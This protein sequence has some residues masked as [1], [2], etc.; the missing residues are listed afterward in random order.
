MQPA[1][2]TLYNKNAG[3]GQDIERCNSPGPIGSPSPAHVNLLRE[4]LKFLVF[5]SGDLVETYHP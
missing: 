5:S 3:E 1:M 4:K 2:M